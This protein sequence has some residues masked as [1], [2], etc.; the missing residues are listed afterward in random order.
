MGL[1]ILCYWR[2]NGGP[3][4][5]QNLRAG[6]EKRE[7]SLRSHLNPPFPTRK[8]TFRPGKVLP[9][10]SCISTLSCQVLGAQSIGMAS[11]D[12]GYR[13]AGAQA[14]V[15]AHPV[16]LSSLNTIIPI[17]F[18]SQ[19]TLCMPELTRFEGWPWTGPPQ[20]RAFH[21]SLQGPQSMNLYGGPPGCWSWG[22]LWW[23]RSTAPSVGQSCIPFRASSAEWEHNI[24]HHCGVGMGSPGTWQGIEGAGMAAHICWAVCTR[25]VLL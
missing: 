3:E 18:Y 22:Y 7:T 20:R 2:G 12:L 19:L 5:L 17:W 21:W 10:W 24:I 1:A 23:D 11:T 13:K 14:G 15:P 9:R 8:L 6:E 25:Q 4:R 16:P